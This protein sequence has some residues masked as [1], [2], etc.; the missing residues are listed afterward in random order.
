MTNAS[1]VGYCTAIRSSC[2]RSARRA[3]GALVEPIELRLVPGAHARQLPG[4]G[5]SRRRRS[6]RAAPLSAVQ[7]LARGGRHGQLRQRAEAKSGATRRH[8]R[9]RARIGRSHAGQQLQHAK[10]R[11]AVARVVGPAQ[12]RKQ[13]LDVRGL[14]ELETAVLHER[15]VAAH[16]LELEQVAVVRGAKEHGLAPQRRC[17]ARARSSTRSTT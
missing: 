8:R 2:S 5:R 1:R 6:R 15:D 16:Q 4:P 3:V 10:R 13:V 14:E 12:H 9:A 11:D 7:C 17:R